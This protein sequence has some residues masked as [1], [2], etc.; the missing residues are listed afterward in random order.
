[1]TMNTKSATAATNAPTAKDETKNTA[2]AGNTKATNS[3]KFIPMTAEEQD[4]YKKLKENFHDLDEKDEAR[5]I[6]L[7]KKFKAAESSKGSYINQLK[8][9]IGQSGL[10]ISDLFKPNEVLNAFPFKDLFTAEEL[11][12]AIMTTDYGIK[13]LFTQDKI[14][15]LTGKPRKSQGEGA[16]VD[17]AASKGEQWIK[18]PGTAPKYYKGQVYK[19]MSKKQIEKKDFST[20]LGP[21]LPKGWLTNDTIEILMKEWATDEAKALYAAKN[22]QFMTEMNDLVTAITTHKDYV[23]SV[24]SAAAP[25]A[26]AKQAA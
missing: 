1:M 19:K 23:A 5:L 4:T 12:A 6:E 26:D 20:A 3:E 14:S 24:G 18:M 2:S 10:T 25:K 21:S 11:K 16:S 15:A 8:N 7:K 13:D 17:S 22:E 9:E